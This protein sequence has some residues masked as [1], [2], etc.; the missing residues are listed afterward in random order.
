MGFLPTMLAHMLMQQTKDL[1]KLIYTTQQC[2]KVTPI[3]NHM[4][5]VKQE[6]LIITHNCNK[7]KLKDLAINQP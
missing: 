5:Q 4:M 7:H 3:K 1:Q 6:I 2:Q